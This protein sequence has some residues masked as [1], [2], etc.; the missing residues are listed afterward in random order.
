MT[1]RRNELIAE[2]MSKLYTRF[3]IFFRGNE[4]Q[5]AAAA[6]LSITRLR[7]VFPEDDESTVNADG[8]EE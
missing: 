4:K 1:T 2:M 6:A 3:L 5:A 7:T 8:S